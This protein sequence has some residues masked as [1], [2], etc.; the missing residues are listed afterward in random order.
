MPFPHLSIQ[1]NSF[2][3][4]VIAA[5]Q[6]NTFTSQNQLP[7]LCNQKTEGKRKPSVTNGC[8]DFLPCVNMHKNNS[9][10]K[11]YKLTQKYSNNHMLMTQQ[12]HLCYFT[13]VE[14]LW[15]PI[16]LQKLVSSPVN[17]KAISTSHYSDFYR[18]PLVRTSQAH[19]HNA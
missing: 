8:Y 1:K 13:E 5:F 15:I 19:L 18:N 7:S 3:T 6:T 2:N 4:F 14:E 9:A 12:N 10:Q 17:W 16:I 11:I